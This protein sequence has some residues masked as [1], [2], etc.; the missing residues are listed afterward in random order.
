MTAH[1]VA[2]PPLPRTA[3]HI[4]H[5]L[6]VDGFHTLPNRVW[7]GAADLAELLV[8]AEPTAAQRIWLWTAYEKFLETAP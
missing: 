6:R 3:H 8:D 1:L 4:A 5:R 2:F 7:N